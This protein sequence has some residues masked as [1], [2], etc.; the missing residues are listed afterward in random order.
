M[1]RPQAHPRPG[2][3]TCCPCDHTTPED[4]E[5]FKKYPLHTARDTL[6]GWSPAEALRQHEGWPIHS[7]AHQAIEHLFRDPLVKE[8]I[9]RGVVTQA[10]HQYLAKHRESR[11]E[12]AAHLQLDA[13]RRAASQ[14][15]HRKHLV[16]DTHGTTQRP[17]RQGTTCSMSSI[18]MPCMTQKSTNPLRARHT[19]PP[20][21]SAGLQDTSKAP[22][23]PPLTQ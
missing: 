12:A 23:S 15:V 21:R 1:A 13:V 11:M 3:H 2:K 10:L 20:S 8:A 4:W 5:H 9:M 18:T 17:H 14:M 19:P 22:P 7:H 6:V 16:V